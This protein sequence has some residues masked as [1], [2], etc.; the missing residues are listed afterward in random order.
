MVDLWQIQC[1]EWCSQT[2]ADAFSNPAISIH[3]CLVWGEF[4]QLGSGD[5]W[6][7]WPRDPIFFLINTGKFWG[8]PGRAWN[9]HFLMPRMRAMM[10]ENS[11][12]QLL[13]QLFGGGW[14]L[15][16]VRRCL[17]EWSRIIPRR[18]WLTTLVRKPFQVGLSHL[19]LGSKAYWAGWSSNVPSYFDKTCPLWGQEYFS[20]LR[21]VP[22]THW[23]GWWCFDGEL[24]CWTRKKRKERPIIDRWHIGGCQLLALARLRL[25]FCWVRPCKA[26]CQLDGPAN[27]PHE[28]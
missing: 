2:L 4:S 13:G 12:F 15:V 6:I 17:Q 19:W 18:K 23:E 7:F 9:L 10:T 28:L 24:S 26:V 20:A 14:E 8:S 5:G 11:T 25:V 1:H 22:W 21:I 3:F 27:S 16:D